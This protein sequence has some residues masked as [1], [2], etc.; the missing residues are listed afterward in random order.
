LENKIFKNVAVYLLDARMK[1]A[2]VFRRTP[3]TDSLS[4]WG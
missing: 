1:H 3:K 2:S 4:P